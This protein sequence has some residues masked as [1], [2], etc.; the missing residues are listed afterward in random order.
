MLTLVN[1][2][3][4]RDL[5]PQEEACL[6]SSKEGQNIVISIFIAIITPFFHRVLLF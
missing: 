5:Q 3:N 6:H 1:Q 2:T 4:G